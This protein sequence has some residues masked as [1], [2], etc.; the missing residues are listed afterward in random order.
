MTREQLDAFENWICVLLT[1]HTE[2]LYVN[3]GFVK[4]GLPYDSE[5]VL[6][7]S[8]AAG[9]QCASDA[10]KELEKALGIDQ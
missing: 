7:G 10:R 3:R 9:H 1:L 5:E 2:G 6:Y 8:D 4:R